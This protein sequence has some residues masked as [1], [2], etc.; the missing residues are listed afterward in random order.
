M[1]KL[2][3]RN[4]DALVDLLREKLA[5]ARIALSLYDRVLASD[6]VRDLPENE[7]MREALSGM[8]EQ[9]AE[10][11]AFLDARLVKL[12]EAAVGTPRGHLRGFEE[13]ARGPDASALDLILALWGLELAQD[14]AWELLLRLARAVDDD[15]AATALERRSREEHAH[16]VLL[17]DIVHGIIRVQLGEGMGDIG[18][19]AA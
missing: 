2:A 6:T 19:L 15:E 18:R 4:H 16:A 17:R 12:G 13:V 5:E 1:Q 8:R 9:E 14:G 7:E 10:H 3:A 11:V